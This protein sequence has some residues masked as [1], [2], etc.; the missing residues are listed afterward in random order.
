MAYFT[1]IQ[2]KNLLDKTGIPRGTK[3]KF[4]VKPKNGVV[5]YN[6]SDGWVQVVYSNSELAQ[7]E[8]MHPLTHDAQGIGIIHFILVDRNQFEF[9]TESGSNYYRKAI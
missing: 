4:G 2:I 6:M 9:R 7:K 5:T 1:A 8:N 3:A